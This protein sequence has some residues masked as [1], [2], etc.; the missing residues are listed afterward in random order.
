MSN[1][2]GSNIKRLQLRLYSEGEDVSDS[3]ALL[4]TLVVRHLNRLESLSGDCMKSWVVAAL[5]NQYLLEKGHNIRGPEASAGSTKAYGEDVGN[6]SEALEQ[7]Q[8]S[9]AVNDGW[10]LDSPDAE[11]FRVM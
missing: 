9:D 4:E 8:E 10:H 1:T 3:D 2:S 6:S 11:S 7:D 5:K